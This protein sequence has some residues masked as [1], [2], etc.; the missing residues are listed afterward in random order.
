MPLSNLFT[1]LKKPS[2]AQTARQYAQQARNEE[3]IMRLR[4]GCC[5]ARG[6]SGLRYPLNVLNITDQTYIDTHR[7]SN[8]SS[9]S[10]GIPLRAEGGTESAGRTGDRGEGSG[11]NGGDDGAD[12]APPPRE[13]NHIHTHHSHG[14]THDHGLGG[15]HTQAHLAVPTHDHGTTPHSHHDHS[16]SSA[17]GGGG[18]FSSSSAGGM[19]GGMGGM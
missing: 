15:S 5:S 18:G 14:G 7:P 2:E 19:G 6:V 3:R 17:F 9:P 10:D 8:K 11:E 4:G 12:P 16:S 1:K 13:H